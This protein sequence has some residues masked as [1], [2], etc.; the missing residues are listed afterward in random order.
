[1]TFVEIVIDQYINLSFDYIFPE[2]LGKPAIGS[3]VQVPFKGTKKNVCII[4]IKSK[5]TISH[6][7]LKQVLNV[8]SDIA[9]LSDS[10][11]QMAKWISEYYGTP[12]GMIIKHIAPS[13]IFKK[14]KKLKQYDTANIADINQTTS[15]ISLN[16]EQLKAFKAIKTQIDN[17]ESKTFLLWGITGSG[18]TEVFIRAIEKVL[19]KKK[20]ALVIVPEIALTPQLTKAFR[21]RFQQPVAVFH[22]HLND[23]DRSDNWHKVNKGEIS[24]VLGARSAVFAPIQN[25]GIIVVDEEHERSFKQEEAPR[26]NARDIAILRASMEKAIVILSSATPSIESFY[27]ALQ[28]K[29]ELLHLSKRVNNSK[30]PKVSL[31]DMEQEFFKKQVNYLFSNYLLQ[32]IQNRLEQK[33]Q[34]IIF[35]N[36]RG[37]STCQTCI[38]CSHVIKC[39]NCSISMTYHKRADKLICHHCQTSITPLTSC[40][41]CNEKQLKFLGFGTEKVEKQIKKI[42]PLAN[43]SRLDTDVV[44]KKGVLEETLQNFEKGK[45]DILVGTQM[46]AKGLHISNVTLVGILSADLSLNIPNFRAG[47]NTFQLITQV[48][49][50]AGRGEK[51][52]EVII[53]THC[54]KNKIIKHAVKQDF[55][56]FYQEEI[57]FRKSFNYPPFTRFILITIHGSNEKKASELA[58]NFYSCIVKMKT[59]VSRIYPPIKSPI[60]KIKTRFR[61]QILL[62]TKAVKSTVKSIHYILNSDFPKEKPKFIV[63]VDPY[64]MV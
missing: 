26:Y 4:A 37:F 12:L 35:L 11:L 46:I 53:Q 43:I 10:M 58:R 32:A 55:L 2:S 48:A 34:I 59:K 16:P 23:L 18:K 15:S 5:S 62:S 30:L 9:P 8:L 38:K 36:K 52:G 6:I 50:R 13:Y 7:K 24:I 54:A 3:F 31:V 57:N 64:S 17:K 44:R 28:H 29:Y 14:R 51:E 49:G 20:T 42:F 56:S 60:E 63:D 22:S 47:E 25:L 1:M 41:E 33:E 45:I 19:E 40:P 61:F 27:N 21:N 39:R